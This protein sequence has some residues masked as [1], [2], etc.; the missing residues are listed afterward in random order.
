MPNSSI[1]GGA[2]RN[3]DEQARY[4]AWKDKTREAQVETA[5]AKQ[6]ATLA[7]HEAAQVA[8]KAAEDKKKIHVD[9]ANLMVRLNSLT[10]N[11]NM[12]QQNNITINAQQLPPLLFFLVRPR[13]C[14]SGSPSRPSDSLR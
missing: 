7:R 3:D 10:V 8:R 12:L 2:S 13:S 11:F 5:L 9:I 14:S 4:Q 6:E 1:N